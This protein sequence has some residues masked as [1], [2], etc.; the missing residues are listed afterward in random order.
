MRMTVG[1]PNGVGASRG[2][3]HSIAVIVALLLMATVLGALPAHATPAGA[4]P[5]CSGVGA[6]RILVDRPGSTFEAAA[7]DNRGRLLLSDWIGNRLAV[8]DHPGAAAGTLAAV[9][10]PGGLAPEPGGGVLVGSGVTATTLGPGTAAARLLKIDPATGKTTVRAAG[11][12][13]ANGVARAPDGTVYMS[14]GAAAG[15]DRV[16]P[17]GHVDRGWYRA[18]PANGLAVSADGK[19]L[20]ANVSLGDARI[21]AIDTKTGAAHTWFRPPSSLSW[22][23]LDDLDIDRAGRL[24]V[25]AYLA[26]Q[27]WRIDPNR[28][29][30]ALA[31]GLLV[32][33]GISVGADG[34]RVDVAGF[35][36]RNVYVTTHAGRVLE[37]PR[38]VPGN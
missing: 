18:T 31:T 5:M 36:H 10:S 2:R 9:D 15:I 19:T 26:G 20:Y 6:P 21:L 33:A 28:T 12:S 3:R 22:A 13:G 11:L 35:S 17:D 14:S 29:G 4:L 38:A 32:P 27:V 8:L 23:F 30:C 1:H 16:R 25:A 37:I 7:F 24:Y 34:G